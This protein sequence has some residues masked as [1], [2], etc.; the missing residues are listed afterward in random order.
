LI[1]RSST[2]RYRA[3][4]AADAICREPADFDLNKSLYSEPDD[5]ACFFDT[6]HK[7]QSYTDQPKS[8]FSPLQIV[9]GAG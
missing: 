1:A 4:N 5:R 6:T 2:A 3:S 9:A 7:N 8:A